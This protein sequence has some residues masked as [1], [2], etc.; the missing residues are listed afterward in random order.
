MINNHIKSWYTDKANNRDGIKALH[1]FFMAQRRN[2]CP[3]RLERRIVTNIENKKEET[4]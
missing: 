1:G 3:E 4:I 2:K